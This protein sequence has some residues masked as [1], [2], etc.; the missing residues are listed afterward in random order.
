[1]NVMCTFDGESVTITDID[2]NGASIYIT[3]VDS[4]NLLKVKKKNFFTNAT[5]VTI[6]SDAMV[7]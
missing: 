4:A 6:A 2:I 1:M 5:I 7:G 3:Y